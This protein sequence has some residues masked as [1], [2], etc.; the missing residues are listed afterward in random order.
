MCWAFSSIFFTIGGRRVGPVVVNRGRLV[1]AVAMVSIA[2]LILLGRPFPFGTSPDRVLWFGLSALIGLVLGDTLLFQ[3]YLLVGTRIGMLLMSLNPIFG[4]LLAWPLLGE[5]L[6]PL[7]VVAMALAL[8]GATWVV[9]ERSGNGKDAAPGDRRKYAT[10]ALLALGAGVCQALGLIIAKRGLA[11]NYSPLSAVVIRMSI[12]MSA[13][14]L[15]A[16]VQR[17]AGPTVRRLSSDRGA[18]LA[19]MGG[20]LAGPFLGVWLSLVAV[21]SVEVGIAS[22][23][24]AMTPVFLLPLVHWIYREKISSRAIAGTLVAVA[25]VAA[26]FFV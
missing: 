7:E 25:G 9:A 15:A 12:A 18:G 24:M 26:M 2:H 11:D 4:A 17:E 22:T 20:A 13:M 8:G 1:A 16:L 21:Q 3:S 5:T 10:G 14:W 6:A 19:I 23:L